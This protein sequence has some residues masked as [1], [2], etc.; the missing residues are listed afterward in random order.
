MHKELTVR[1][2]N[3]NTPATTYAFDDMAVECRNFEDVRMFF[4]AFTTPSR[5]TNSTI[6]TL[7]S[8]ILLDTPESP[9]TTIED[10]VEFPESPNTTIESPAT[11]PT[12]TYNLEL[13]RSFGYYDYSTASTST[14][15]C[16][17]FIFPP[18]Y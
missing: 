9:T 12:T 2:P 15:S 7:S 3:V 17:K 1:I 16:T 18:L 13:E 14:S 4:S 8:T 5:T 6:S 11:S 10:N